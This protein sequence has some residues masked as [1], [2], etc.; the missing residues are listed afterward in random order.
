M[1]KA[2]M[3]AT[4]ALAGCATAQGALTVLQAA[5]YTRDAY[6]GLSPEGRAAIRARVGL[7]VQ[8]IECPGDAP[9]ISVKVEP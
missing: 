6:C 3:I 7:T 5:G 8:V 4:L 9:R 2:L 1:M